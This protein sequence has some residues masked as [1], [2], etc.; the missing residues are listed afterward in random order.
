M[1]IYVLRWWPSWISDRHKKQKVG[2]GH[3]SYGERQ[4]ISLIIH[5]REGVVVV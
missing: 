2:K 5:R 1:L 3:S 4:I